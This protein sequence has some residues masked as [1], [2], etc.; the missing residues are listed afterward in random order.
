MA[1]QRK[2]TVSIPENL[3]KEAQL[4]TNEGITATVRRGLQLLVTSSAYKKL[5]KLRGKVKFSLDI[6]KLREHQE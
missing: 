3:L 4:S 5:R 6:D 1:N 2:I